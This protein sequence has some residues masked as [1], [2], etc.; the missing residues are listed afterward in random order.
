MFTPDELSRLGQHRGLAQEAQA[1]L[2]HIC[3]SPPARRVG[4]GGKNV[5]VL[6]PSR[7]MGVIMQAESSK[8]E[9]AG[10][11]EMEHDSAVL[12]CYDQPPPMKLQYRAK[13]G[14]RMGVLHTPDYFVIPTDSLGW[15]EWKMEE[16]LVH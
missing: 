7:K 15:E 6:Y 13:N 4:S 11:Y 14:R 8:N 12:A 3:S 16:D 10:V 1:V 5:P 2:T 9:L